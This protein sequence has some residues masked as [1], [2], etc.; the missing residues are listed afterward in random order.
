MPVVP[1]RTVYDPVAG[2]YMHVGA[3]AEKMAMDLIGYASVE[4]TLIATD[5]ETPGLL[6]QFEVNCVTTAWR[7]HDGEVHAL[8]LDPARVPAHG[9][10]LHDVYGAAHRIVLHNAPFDV[11]ALV[12]NGW[13]MLDDIDKV[14]DTLVLARF[15]YPGAFSAK[16][17]VLSVRDLGMTFAAGGMERLFNAAGFRNKDD[18]YANM[19]IGSPTY[20]QGAMTDTIATLAL[21]D[22][23]REAC[24]RWATDHPFRDHGATTRAEA[25]DLVATQETVN[26]VMLARTAVGLAVD[27]NY[28]ET[29]RETVHHDRINYTAT[30]AKA[31]LEGGS[32]KGGQVLEYLLSIGEL[33]EPWPRT[34]KT[35]ALKA[36]KELMEDLDHPMALAQRQLALMD[37]MLVYL[38]KVQRQAEVTGRCHP[39]VSILGASKSG[40]MS[41]G[42]PEL[43]QFPGPAR[44]ILIDDGQGLTS[45]DWA[46]IEPVT[47]AAMA[48]DSQFIDPFEAGADLYAPIM[49]SCGIDR[50]LAKVVL[51]A[52]MYGQGV[53]S[54]ARRI[55]HTPESAQQIRKQMLSAMPKCAR[56]MA[57]TV[58]IARQYGKTCTAGGRILQVDPQVT[59]KAVNYLCQGSAY[60]VLAATIVEM[61][62][63]G[64]DDRIQLAMHDEVVVDSEV[65]DEVREIML[66][67]PAFLER[68]AGRTPVLRT[69]MAD[70]GHVWQKV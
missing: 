24:Y 48:Q 70:M 30:L 68:W 46:Q 34:P 61:H 12:R 52:T 13:L 44:S 15:A 42:S 28:L 19:D 69:D 16:L 54:L 21:E 7:H 63:R 37:K 3:D 38:E 53:N 66:T 20:R 59:Y 51:L 29:Y 57:K 64:I 11:P 1:D 67:P 39:Q 27:L 32:G 8:L 33:P 10:L 4:D 50:P 47:M 41:Y 36:T 26:R 58:D 65:A 23:L 31:G 45:I 56:F 40:R 60:D 6:R 5:I 22:I 62:R 35:G 2:A 55:K 18:G 49:R 14:V 17:E 9:D 25:M 43:Q